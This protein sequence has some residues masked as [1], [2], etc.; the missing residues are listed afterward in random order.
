[1]QNSK[2]MF[3][4]M[5]KDLTCVISSGRIL[6][7]G[8]LMIKRRTEPVIAGTPSVAAVL[9]HV[10]GEIAS[11][12]EAGIADRVV[13]ILPEQATIR[14][15]EAQK[16]KNQRVSD[17]GSVLIKDWMLRGP[18]IEAESWS[19]ALTMFGVAFSQYKGVILW[20]SARS[21]YRWELKGQV[22]DGSDL[23]KLEGQEVTFT[24]GVNVELGI[25][26]ENEHYNETVKVNVTK[27][28]QR[29][30]NF[31]YRAF[32]PRFFSVKGENGTVQMLDS[33]TVSN[34]ELAVEGSNN[35]S[36]A[37]INALRLHVRTAEKLPRVR[38]ATKIVVEDA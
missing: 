8:T 14:A 10:A 38:V 16:L 24:S 28:R 3:D 23:A 35:G 13:F 31:R 7:D 11:L 2:I 32:V 6:E 33:F 22:P 12:N 19:T 18:Q 21:L 25:A 9:A 4:I 5:V 36:S 29:N 34:P 17:I 15:A 1:M 30:G 37:V 26:V 20:H 27:I